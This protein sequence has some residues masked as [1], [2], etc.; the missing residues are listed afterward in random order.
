M[1]KKKL[2]VGTGTVRLE[3]CGNFELEHF[4]LL[5]RSYIESQ[6][7]NQYSSSEKKCRSREGH[8]TASMYV[9]SRLLGNNV[10]EDRGI[11]DKCIYTSRIAI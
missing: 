6:S 8:V 11:N 9:T 2:P 1:T 3:N 7:H 10:T 4:S 5:A